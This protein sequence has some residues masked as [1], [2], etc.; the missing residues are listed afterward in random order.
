M[1]VGQAIT[2]AK[3]KIE[4]CAKE[5]FEQEQSEYRGKLDKCEASK[6]SENKPCGK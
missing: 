3:T 5:R 6:E 1:P 4:G 2:E